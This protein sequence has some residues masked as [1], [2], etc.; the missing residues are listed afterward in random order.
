MAK[1]RI[2]GLESGEQLDLTKMPP[3]MLIAMF[4]T[5][6]YPLSTMRNEVLQGL[7]K[8][9]LDPQ[10]A[11]QLEV[12][13]SPENVQGD[14]GFHC[15]PLAKIS[16]RNP[17]HIASE[18]VNSLN[19]NL[20]RNGVIAKYVAVGPY[21][22]L[23]LNYS[24]FSRLVSEKV[25]DMKGE[26]GKEKI[27]T[28]QRMALDMSSPNIAKPMS[29][30]HLRSTVIGRSLSRIFEHLDFDVIKD[31]HIGDW[32]TQFGHLL[33]AIEL[34]GDWDVINQNPIDEL[35]K[36]YVR[37]SDEGDEKST[38]YADLSPEEAQEK[39]GK[40]KDAGR[41]WF[42]RLEQGD[43]EARESWL[44]IVEWSMREFQEM[45]DMFKVD[46]DW[47]RG[48]SFY[49]DQLPSTVERLQSS[50]I[51]SEGKEGAIIVNMEDVGL[52]VAMVL[53]SDKATLYLTREI[54]TA[55]HRS[56]V[57]HCDAMVYVVGED[58]KFYFEQ[59]FEILRRMG[60]P[61]ADKSKH[62]YFGMVRLDEGKMSTRKGHVILL[63]DVVTK[64][65]EKTRELVE[66]RTQVDDAEKENLIRQVATGAIVWNDLKNDP[67]GTVIFDWD[68]MLSME[69][70]S[71]PYVQYSHVRA[72][73]LLANA[74]I[75]PDLLRYAE[76]IP[77]D[78]SEQEL[79]KMIAAFPESVKAAAQ[80]YNPSKIANHIYEI[81]KTF[82]IFY[83]DLSV[84]KEPDQNKKMSRL[85]LTAMVA[86]T[87]KTGL[88]LL[89]IEAPQRM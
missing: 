63:K 26:Y 2:E 18:L 27:G 3:E 41:A 61:I 62:V 67:K 51:L 4:S 45:Y 55:I 33:R 89:G 85:A 17:V 9:G 80:G 28:G 12:G 59:F 6:D 88:Y 37:I 83:H 13:R 78:A 15:A 34:W 44:R 47:S 16:K 71:A 21:V 82:N 77:E 57:E 69:G 40:V 53:K 19:E 84:L 66:Q 1:R 32:G 72:C 36:L 52:D 22:N 65:L 23:V 64:A 30:G 58:Q 24:N 46:F 43:A 31:N 50:G 48:E 68:N 39:A 5:P 35:Q 76:I 29:I 79:I 8:I 11:Q 87:I 54:A 74:N 81:A 56:E 86:E 75:D 38:L 70:N 60:N 25:F 49:E 73:S 7:T 14:F 20:D 10:L 42:K